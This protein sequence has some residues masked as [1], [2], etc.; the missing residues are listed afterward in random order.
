MKLF[1]LHRAQDLPI[2][3]ETAWAFFSDPT[4]LSRITPAWLALR[5]VS[6][7]VPQMH[8]GLVIEYR[9]RLF[10]G[11]QTPWITEITHVDRPN[12]FVDEQRFGPCRFW[13]HLHR[14]H[15]IDGG[16][17]ATDRVHYALGLGPLGRLAERWFVRPRLEAIFDFR[18]DALARLLG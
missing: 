7:A 16:V 10:G 11:I 18:R 2:D 3:P 5:I 14:F 15:P 12:L 6:G 9:V 8:P 17:R 1:H 4:N 13:H